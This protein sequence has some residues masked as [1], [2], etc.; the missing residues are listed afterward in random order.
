MDRLS[1]DTIVHVR[2]RILSMR[3]RGITLRVSG[4]Q[5]M[6]GPARLLEPADMTAIAADQEAFLTILRLGECP[7]CHRILD[8]KGRCWKCFERR[9]SNCT[10]MTGSAF[11]QLCFKCGFEETEREREQQK[12]RG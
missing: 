2:L 7:N 11:F 10:G 12:N 4:G 3:D 6:A 1:E 8:A 5:V 9:C